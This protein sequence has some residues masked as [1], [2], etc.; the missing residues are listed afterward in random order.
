MR[1]AFGMTMVQRRNT[2]SK[3]GVPRRLRMQ[4]GTVRSHLSENAPA[5]RAGTMTGAIKAG[6][7]LMKES[8]LVPDC[9]RFDC[10]SYSE[11]WR[12]VNS[13]DGCGVDRKLGEA[14]WTFFLLAGEIRVTV[15]AFNREK[16]LRRAVRRL[17]AK[18]ETGKFNSLEI[19]RIAA[20][21]VLGPL[22]VTVSAHAR[23]IQ[24]GMVLRPAA[25]RAEQD[26]VGLPAA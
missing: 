24:Q 3:T 4:T 5:E 20:R 10:E 6:T 13:L 9:I 19:T 18:L 7:I 26:R 25:R 21:R 1:P 15:I 17:L 11:G 2:E 14:G 12:A 23:H 16:A 22:C 8:A